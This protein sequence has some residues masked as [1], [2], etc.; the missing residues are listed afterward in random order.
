MGEGHTGFLWGN[1]RER[2][3]L[4]GLGVDG[5]LILKWISKEYNSTV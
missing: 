4:E 2:E 3:H 1:Q 5:E